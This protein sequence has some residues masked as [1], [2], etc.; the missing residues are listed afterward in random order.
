MSAPDKLIAA[1]GYQLRINGLIKA[2]CLAFSVFLL[3]QA[4]S[5]PFPINLFVPLGT[6][7]YFIYHFSV[8]KNQRKKAIQI[9]HKNFPTL[10]FSL[11]LLDKKEK[12][13]VEKLQLERLGAILHPLKAPVVFLEHTSPFFILLLASGAIMGI[14]NYWESRP[15]TENLE[16]RNIS[17]AVGERNANQP[18]SIQDVRVSI[19]PPS[20]T[21][22]KEQEQSELSIRAIKGSNLTWE[23]DFN[24]QDDFTVTLVNVGGDEVPF[25]KESRVY[26]LSDL[27]TG[28]G[29]YA[30]RAYRD[31]SIVFESAYYSLEM[32]GDQPPV[33]LPDEKEVYRYHFA[34]DPKSYTLKAQISDDFMVTEAFVIATVA[35]GS[36]ENVRFREIRMPMEKRNFAQA[37]LTKQVD[38]AELGF[39]PGDE[40]YYYWAAFDNQAPQPNFSR[41]DTYFI[42][43][44]DSSGLSESQLAG[45]AVNVL[46]EYFRSQR[47]IIIDTEKL[48]SQRKELKEATFNSTSNE[49][50][51][52]QKLL[53]MRYGQYLG[54]EFESDAGGASGHLENGN[55]I[56]ESFMH[57]HDHEGN[58]GDPISKPEQKDAEQGKKSLLPYIEEVHDHGPESEGDNELND[59]LEQYL[60]NHDSGEMN[61]YFEESTR[62]LLKMALEQMWQSELHLRLFEPEKALPFQHK[63]LEYL[64]TVQQKSRVYVQRTG[65]DPPPIREV[66]KRL[67]GEM[68]ELERDIEV[69]LTGNNDRLPSLAAKI[70]ALIEKDE[71]SEGDQQVVQ[72]FSTLWIQRLQ[73]TGIQDWSLLVLLQKVNSSILDPGE[74]QNLIQKLLPLVQDDPGRL[75]SPSTN[76]ALE[77]AFWNNLK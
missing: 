48:I 71:L 38:L 61:T 12:N 32:Y 50:G 57:L 5:L 51:F 25:A 41:S 72:E 45:M 2:L 58:D 30:I 63:A 56:L 26:V 3:S 16:K 20:Y 46:P 68:K 43:Y 55:N 39:K 69:Q 37:E 9:L 33:I 66:E 28:S 65:F 47:Q 75:S 59:L 49:I 44:V 7:L 8:I 54:E 34:D 23:L 40:L 73:Y 17:L 6:L 10:E 14:S 18:I 15:V 36:G 11:E 22:Q 67:S 70:I 27:L 4:I 62:G 53:R 1:V 77:K 35:S 31:T 64:K 76:K 74:R 29:L 42:Q 52:D 19:T 60:H 21:K 13:L 24:R